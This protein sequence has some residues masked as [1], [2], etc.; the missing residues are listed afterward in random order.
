MSYANVKTAYSATG[1]GTTDDTT[2]VQNALT[3]GP[4]Y[5]PPGEYRISTGLTTIYPVKGAGSRHS[6]ISSATSSL[7]LLTV[8]DGADHIDIEGIRLKHDTEGTGDGLV[9]ERLNHN[10]I[11][12]GVHAVNCRR[13]ISSANVSFQ[14]LYIQCR[15]DECAVGFYA[16]GRDT[17]DSSSGTTL[18]YDQCYAVN[19]PQ[20]FNLN[21]ITQILMNQM[22]IDMK[23]RTEWGVFATGIA[24]LYILNGHTEGSPTT[25]WPSND[26]GFVRYAPS[27]NFTGGVSLV[28]C[29]VSFA[30]FTDV[31]WSFVN[32]IAGG[33]KTRL[34]L[35][36]NSI[37]KNTTF[38]GD[39]RIAKLSATSGGRI[40][41][42]LTGNNWDDLSG[43]DT[44]GVPSSAAYKVR[45]TDLFF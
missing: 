17:D 35:R 33:N 45:D 5:F 25:P 6:I 21:Y 9:L 43:I 2:A 39:N 30:D 1:D 37:A 28:G 10:V 12:T 29:D 42:D 23:G 36:D 22:T 8:T 11:V 34:R 40:D 32:V 13:G 27:G 44:S 26:G 3:A 20:G 16:E 18:K 7:D 24:N 38:D 15:T 41:V 19:C 31:D 14:Q 4:T